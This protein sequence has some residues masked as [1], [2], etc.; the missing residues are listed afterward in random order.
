MS[1][2]WEEEPLAG[3]ILDVLWIWRAISLPQHTQVFLPNFSITIC[4]HLVY[5]LVMSEAFI[6]EIM[7]ASG[8]QIEK[9][10]RIMI[11]EKIWL[12]LHL[13]F[14]S[15]NI[16]WLY[17]KVITSANITLNLLFFSAGVLKAIHCDEPRSINRITKDTVI[18]HAADFY[19]LVE[20]LQLDLHEPPVSQVRN[21]RI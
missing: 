4:M 2:A 17:R 5:Y 7:L 18:F 3:N 21:K 10:S 20:M 11:I 15:W 6:A 1:C 19:K 16:V 8:P 13:L 12:C 14:F 9:T